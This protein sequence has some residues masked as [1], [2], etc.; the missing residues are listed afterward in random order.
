[1]PPR[2]FEYELEFEYGPSRIVQT[3]WGKALRRVWYLESGNR[4]L[5]TVTADIRRHTPPSRLESS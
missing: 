4:E 3:R 1:M 5:P 2:R